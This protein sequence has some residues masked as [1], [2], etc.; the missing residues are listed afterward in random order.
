MQFLFQRSAIALAVL[1]SGLACAQ[2]V[3]D[4][5][6]LNQQLQRNRELELPARSELP[7][8]ATPEVVARQNGPV[9]T[10]KAFRFAGNTLLSA[11]QLGPALGA[12]VDRPLGFAQLQQAAAALAEA[13]RK[14]GWIVRTYLPQQEI[15]DGLVTIQV[16]EARFGGTRTE[17][18]ASRRIPEATILRMVQA[19]QPAGAPLKADALDR[20]L[21]LIGDLPGVSVGGTLRAGANDHETDL[22]LRFGERPGASGS[23]TLDNEGARATGAARAV[24]LMT[25]NSLLGQGEQIDGQVIASQ[26]SDFL[27]LSATVPLGSAGWRGGVNGSYLDYRLISSDFSAL[28]AR[29]SSSTVGLQASYPV[30][31]ARLANLYL[32]VNADHKSFDNRS[33]GATTSNYSVDSATVGLSGNH[34]D[35][36]GGGGVSTAEA[37]VA[38]GR[39]DLAGSPN[40][41]ADAATT[42]AGGGYTKIHYSLARRQTLGAD[43]SAYAAL[44]GQWA[45]KNLDSSEKIFLGGADGVRAYPVN[46]AGGSKGQILNLELR[47]RLP[48]GFSATAFYDYGRI[49]QNVGNSFA[50]AA[51]PNGYALQGGGL[52]TS[53]QAAHGAEI[54]ATWAH[55]VGRNPN[56]TSTGADQDGS[57]HLNRFWLSAALSF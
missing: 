27:W 56:P 52:S 28:D 26:G 37:S 7:A 43:W 13:Y 41:A 36:F 15:K 54:K 18:D 17:G 29:G 53:W 30:L 51:N 55:R 33:N 6:A 9:V 49:D 50:G 10:V 38:R 11:E 57:R 47:R 48:R 5:G 39:L 8:V 31:R 25:L 35:E 12:Y 21:L 3:P 45:D 32:S 14:A 2:T 19:Q 40:Q 46:E 16:V 4:A 24:G 1:S 20:A 34:F 44:S 23:V 22:V 42:R